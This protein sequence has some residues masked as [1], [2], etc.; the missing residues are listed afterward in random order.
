MKSIELQKPLAVANFVIEVA[1]KKGNPVTNLKLQKILF[2]L[3]GYFL[4]NYGAPLID[5]SFS[6]WKFGPVEQEVYIEFKDYGSAPIENKSVRFDVESLNFYSEEI[7]VT[8]ALENEIEEFIF[9]IIKKEAWELVDLTHEHYSWKDFKVEI[10]SQTSKNY[11][12]EE[13][14]DCF[15][16][17]KLELGV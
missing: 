5:G 17:S 16:C 11:T 14:A 1:K 10:M 8:S 9:K 3:Q 6:K 2:F 15:N 13:I 4:S 12:D 7:D